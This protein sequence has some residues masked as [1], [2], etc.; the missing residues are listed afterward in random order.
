M[1]LILYLKAIFLG[2]IEGL[3]EFLPVSSTGHLIV[4]SDILEFNTIPNKTFEIIIQ[5]GAILAVC[6]LYR[7][8]IYKLLL[9][10]LTDTSSQKFIFNIFFAF[11]PAVIFGVAFHG[12]IKEYL[13]SPSLVAS[14]L[15]L[16]GFLMIYIEKIKRD[17]KFHAIEEIPIMTAVKIGF[18]Q[19]IA[20]IPGT[21]RSGA[22]ILGAMLLNT[23][24]KTAAE[25]SF[26]LAIPTIF[27]AVIYDSYKN[28]HLMNFDD[29]SLILCGFAAAFISS[30]LVVAKLIAF[31]SKHGFIPFAIYRI[32]IGVIIFIYV[33]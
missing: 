4:L 26:F 22:T 31:I 25:F 19:V 14:M 10:Y 7:E 21:S 2:I 1:Y 6:F 23:S 16:G 8:K 33:I 9:T 11:L 29:V 20:M 18:F 27:S 12:F 30:L 15:M 13:F 17:P 32:I 5:L 24:R 3:T 28:Y